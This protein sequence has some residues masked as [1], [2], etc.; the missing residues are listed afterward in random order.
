MN[1][2][3]G[4]TLWEHVMELL[5]VVFSETFLFPSENQANFIRNSLREEIIFIAYKFA[6]TEEGAVSPR[7]LLP[8][9][10][11]RDRFEKMESKLLH[12]FQNKW[13]SVEKYYFI[14]FMIFNI[15]GQIA[16]R[17]NQYAIQPYPFHF[18]QHVERS[19]LSNL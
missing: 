8:Y 9:I 2:L 17:I 18:E 7:N 1:Q 4:H 14:K 19:K 12:S 5:E 6:E 3:Y 13:L 11:I 10:L 15:E 16:F